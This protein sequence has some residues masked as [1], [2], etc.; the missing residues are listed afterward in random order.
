MKEILQTAAKITGI[1][2]LKMYLK[3]KET[4]IS[5]A[6]Q[7]A[8]YAMI[9]KGYTPKLAAQYFGLTPRSATYSVEQIE[10]LISHPNEYR[11]P[12][13]NAL[14]SLGITPFESELNNT[15]DSLKTLL[16]SKAH[17]Y[18]NSDPLSNFKRTASLMN[19]SPE[20]VILT[21]IAQKVSRL[22]NLLLSQKSPKNES[23]SDSIS[24]LIGYAILL[25]LQIN[26]K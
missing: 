23:V 26:D 22:E 15:I 17:D 9:K 11:E 7:F 4:K 10:S 14:L 18:A 24:D 8:M 16:N 5:L 6:R 3:S 1:D 25:K 13:I 12:I 21:N 20:A 19:S 2:P